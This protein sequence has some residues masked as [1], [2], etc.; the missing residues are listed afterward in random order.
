[1]LHKA[2]TTHLAY[3]KNAV[4][5]YLTQYCA[6]A[7]NPTLTGRMPHADDMSHITNLLYV[8]QHEVD[9]FEFLSHVR[10]IADYC[11]YVLYPDPLY[12]HE[13]W[14]ERRQI[15]LKSVELMYY[16]FCIGFADICCTMNG[17]PSI[18]DE[19]RN[20]LQHLM[21]IHLT[22]SSWRH[23]VLKRYPRLFEWI[24]LSFLDWV[25]GL[26]EIY[27]V[28]TRAQYSPVVQFQDPGWQTYEETYPV[29]CMTLPQWEGEV[30]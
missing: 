26:E 20:A 13:D 4:T 17:N 7:L 27:P 28:F 10:E 1:M 23:V 25:N 15:L 3:L 12:H 19:N 24:N 29:M 18:I 9:T 2:S 8:L 16:V 11:K 21:E 6:D 22:D 5:L 30:H 14:G